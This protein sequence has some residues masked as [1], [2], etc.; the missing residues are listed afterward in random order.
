MKLL[1]DFGNS[2]CKWAGL[3]KENLLNSNVQSYAGKDNEQKVENLIA[4]LPLQRCQQ[5]HAVSVLGAEFD[6]KFA[7]Y[8]YRETAISVTYHYSQRDAFGIQLAYKDPDT[9]GADRYAALVAVHHSGDDA[10]IVV[11]CG[12]A[13]TIDAIESNGRHLGGLIIPGVE[14]MCSTLSENTTGIPSVDFGNAAE[15]LNTNTHDAVVSGSTLCLQL[16]LRSIIAEIEQLL[17][18]RTSIFITGGAR[19][20]L[21]EYCHDRLVERPDLVLEGLHIMQSN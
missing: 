4:K 15:Y 6:R 7:E 13:V 21:A 18:S 17:A 5:V 19:A 14:L 20:V 8:V 16:G 12:T 10:K 1:I 3:E 11:D 2:R 9:Y